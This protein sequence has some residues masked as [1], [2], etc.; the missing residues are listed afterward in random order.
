MNWHKDI[1]LE[2]VFELQPARP[3][4][5]F[6]IGAIQKFDNIMS[7]LEKEKEKALIITGSSSYK[8]S[9]AWDTVKP[10]LEEK[11]IEYNHYD[12]VRPN[13]TF[14]YCD[15]I[16]EQGIENG[17]DLIISIGGG[18]PHDTAKTV[19]ALIENPEKTAEDFYLKGD[20]IKQATDIININLTHGTGSE[21][22]RV[23][24][25]QCDERQEKPAILSKSLYPRYSI[26]D[27]ELTTT[28]PKQQTISTTIDAL[29]HVTEAAT[30]TVT[31]P[32]SINLAK[33]TTEL[34]EK[35]LPKAKENPENLTARYYLMYASAIA[36]ISFDIGL[37]HMTHAFEHTL[38]AYD[39]D[40]T[41]GLGLGA[42]LPSIVKSIY[43]ETTDI[44]AH[45]YKPIVP[46]LE[47][48]PKEADYAAEKIE[49]WLFEVGC[50]VKLKDLGFKQEE[51]PELVEDTMNSAISGALIPLT[52]IDVN[53]ETVTTIF[54]ESMTP[55]HK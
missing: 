20:P 23:A 5:Y 53:E 29:N 19:A 3:I 6:G 8:K 42:L 4:T 11:N 15:K 28:L 43:P 31:N 47:G 49:E 24:V 17:I 22:D 1:D 18:S 25:A 51:I 14:D 39:P 54:Q 26:E 10:V 32:Y 21:V 34:I 37:L 41:H 46:E 12:D 33:Q 30:T 27:P 13:P 45:V 36:G 35:Y 55:I 40:V 48:K 44:I 2:N 50:D 7:K 38:S 16:A 9:G 52:P